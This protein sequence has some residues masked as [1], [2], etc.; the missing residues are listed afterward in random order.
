MIAYHS[1]D[2]EDYVNGLTDF[3]RKAVLEIREAVLS[4][5]SRVKEGIKWGSIAFF[6]KKNICG[7]RIAKNHVTILFMEGASLQDKFHI[8]A[9]DGVKARTYKVTEKD[10]VHKKAL[11]DLVCQCLEKGL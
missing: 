1:N 9:G 5:D 3:Q 8:L 4:A 10:T 7:Y 6:H 11:T 2:I